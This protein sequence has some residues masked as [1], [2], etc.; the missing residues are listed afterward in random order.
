M[1]NSEPVNAYLAPKI[2]EN[3][4]YVIETVNRETTGKIWDKL[5]ELGPKL[6]FQASTIQKLIRLS[7]SNFNRLTQNQIYPDDKSLLPD[8]K[9]MY[10]TIWDDSTKNE[11]KKRWAKIKTKTVDDGP[12]DG[13]DL[14]ILSTT[15]KLAQDGI[16]ELLTFDHDFILFAE[17][18]FGQFGVSVKN[19]WLLK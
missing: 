8:V 2:S 18:I 11:K 4:I 9:D 13:P 5:S 3:S 14:T 15:A 19:G 17:E 1:S 16:V 12:P 10:A 6:S 7:F